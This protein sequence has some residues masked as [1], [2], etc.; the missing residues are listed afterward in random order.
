M[1]T[2]FCLLLAIFALILTGV[3][4]VLRCIQSLHLSQLDSY[5]NTR[6]LKWL[7]VS[8]FDRLFDLR[9]GLLSLVAIAGQIGLSQTAFAYSDC[10]FLGL[11]SIASV[12]LLFT[13]KS[14][15]AKKPLI[16]TGRAIRILSVALMIC[17]IAIMLP[18]L[19]FGATIKPLLILAVS[20]VVIQASPISVIIANILL[21]PIQSAINAGY[22]FLAKRKIREMHPLVI[23]VAGSYGKTSTKYIVSTIVA[24]RFNVLKTPQS[25]N[26][27]LGLCRVINNDLLSS[28]EVLVAEMGAYRRGEVKET[29]Q[30]VRPKI[31]II[32]SIGPEH[33]ERF[34]S[35]ENIEATNYELIEALPEDGGTAV[36]N[37]EIENCRRMADKTTGIRVWRYGL[38]DFDCDHYLRADNIKMSSDGLSFDILANDGRKT[39]VRTKLLGNP[40]VLNI[41]GAACIALE[42]GLSLQEISRGISKL[43]PVPHRLQLIPGH[44]GVTVIDDAYN[45]NPIGA[46]EALNLLSEFKEG[47][48]I[49]VT[50]GMVELGELAKQ[51]NKI[52]GENAAKVCDY[53]FLVGERQTRDIFD[54]LSSSGFPNENIFIATSLNDVTEQL[55]K[56]V[57]AKDVVL[58]ENDLPDLYV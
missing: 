57:R 11:W 50:P 2:N 38:S 44:G 18:V 29:A 15:P 41:L 5:S 42:M 23:G 37:N 19:Y 36:F 40:N 54:G 10:L 46:R 32:T 28:H 43:E 20:L 34:K 16:Y 45:S 25:F 7:W 22:I 17:S 1:N 8:P 52:F 14:T 13:R 6:L 3:W 35:M 30:L 53:V 4:V 12:I 51:E 49:L 21:K 58:F 56:I 55:G 48:K 47:R 9:T 24:E 27:L 33:F 31:G 39:K 26:T